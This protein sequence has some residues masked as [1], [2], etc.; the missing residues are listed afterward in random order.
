MDQCCCPK[1]NPEPWDEKEITWENKKFIQ[2]RVRCFFYIPI[3]FGQVMKRVMKKVEASNVKSEDMI[4]I[5]DQ[6]SLWGSNVFVDVSGDVND[7]K[8]ATISGTFSSKVFEGPYK[9]MGKWIKEMD[10][11]VKSKGKE[12]EKHYF[13]YTT[14]PKCAKKYGKNYV[15]ILS[16]TQ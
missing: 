10:Q 7:G 13:Y 9:D 15:V 2:D 11:Y 6:D 4:V 3:N 14:C 5:S 12:I 1:F 8:M 16:Q